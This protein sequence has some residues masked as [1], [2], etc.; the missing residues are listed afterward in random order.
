VAVEGGR[1][2]LKVTV[3]SDLLCA[4]AMLRARAS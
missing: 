2:N 3:P 4:E 1:D